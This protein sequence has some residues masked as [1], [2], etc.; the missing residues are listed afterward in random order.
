MPAESRNTLSDESRLIRICMTFHLI[1]SSFIST[2]T[3]TLPTHPSSSRTLIPWGCVAEPVRISCTLPLV[4]FPLCWSFFWMIS[5]VRPIRIASR[6]VPRFLLSADDSGFS[7]SHRNS[8]MPVRSGSSGTSHRCQNLLVSSPSSTA[9]PWFSPFKLRETSVWYS[10]E[11][12]SKIVQEFF[13]VTAEVIVTIVSAA[14]SVIRDT[15]PWY[16]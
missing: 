11:R 10:L 14:V 3:A 4:S 13:P 8:P 15:P 7:L 9:Q 12:G 2:I 5:T 16:R 6:H 1:P